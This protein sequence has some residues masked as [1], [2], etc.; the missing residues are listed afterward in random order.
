MDNQKRERCQSTDSPPKGVDKRPLY[1]ASG[2]TDDQEKT[3][4]SRLFREP[5]FLEKLC[6]KLDSYDL[7]DCTLVCRSFMR[8]VRGFPRIYVMRSPESLASLSERVVL[9]V[10]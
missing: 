9:S 8:V 2:T 4:M 7:L 10:S 1:E 6:T 3:G 5:W